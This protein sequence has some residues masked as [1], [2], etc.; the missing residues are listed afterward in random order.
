MKNIKEFKDIDEFKRFVRSNVICEFGEGS[1]GK[2]YVSKDN[3]VIKTMIDPIW[4]KK[5]EEFPDIIM[6]DDMKL[7]SFIFPKELYIVDGIIVGY[8]QD[9]FYGNIFDGYLSSD[10]LF[11]DKLIEA[12]ERFLD[13]TKIITA[14]GYRLYELPR[15]I[16]FNNKQLVAIDTLD[17]IK[18]DVTYQ[19]NVEIVDYAL[20]LEL[21]EIYP[22]IDTNNTF[23][24]EVKKILKLKK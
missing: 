11:L 18:E 17:Y 13:D 21:L 12:R 7:E 2:V 23:D 6:A 19:E 16:L 20:L 10:I 1:E 14:A 8:K 5:L 22:E 15:N 9:R 3:D 4:P 24:K